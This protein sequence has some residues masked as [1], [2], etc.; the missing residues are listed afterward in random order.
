MRRRFALRLPLA[1][2]MAL[3]AGSP[4]AA[5]AQDR[6]T[7]DGDV[8]VRWVHATGEPSFLNGGLGVLRFD[9]EHEGLQLGRAF[10][11]PT[12]RIA[13]RYLRRSQS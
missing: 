4:L 2:V 5:G 1:M 10:L 13:D 12:W 9:P 8:D 6:L 11:A 3:G 7:V